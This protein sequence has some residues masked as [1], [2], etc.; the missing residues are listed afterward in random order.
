[1]TF[2]MPLQSPLMSSWRRSGQHV[3]KPVVPMFTSLLG[4]GLGNY[5]SLKLRECATLLASD[6]NRV[7][8]PNISKSHPRLAIN[9]PRFL[10][11]GTAH[12]HMQPAN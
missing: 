8:C 7:S 1:M 5:S 11:S 6:L 12:H 2:L 4:Y 10:H 9:K 3:R